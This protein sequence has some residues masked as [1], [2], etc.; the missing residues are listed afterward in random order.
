M[1]HFVND[2]HQISLG[3]IYNLCECLC[4]C[5]AVGAANAVEFEAELESSGADFNIAD[6]LECFQGRGARR[7]QVFQG[8]LD[9]VVHKRCRVG[10]SV[11]P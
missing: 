10:Q 9:G 7:L 3:L 8:F 6:P 4:Q 1:L 2:Q 11:A 5:R